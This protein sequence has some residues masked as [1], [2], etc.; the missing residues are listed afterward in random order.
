MFPF[1]PELQYRINR[2]RYIPIHLHSLSAETLLA[3]ESFLTEAMHK[4]EKN[5]SS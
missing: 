1:V 5:T 2:V 4:A 3:I